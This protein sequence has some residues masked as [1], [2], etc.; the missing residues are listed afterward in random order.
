MKVKINICPVELI[1]FFITVLL[2][3]GCSDDLV[4]P[5]ES[6]S[7]KLISTTGGGLA[8]S[9]F[10]EDNLAFITN[11]DGLLI[12]N[13]TD[14]NSPK[15]IGSIGLGTTFGVTINNGLA[16]TVGNSGISVIDFN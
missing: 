10:V 7:L 5:E 9:V 2:L 4:Q 16:F 12:F 13:I 11:N 15:N 3:I 8:Y 1:T 14:R 6:G